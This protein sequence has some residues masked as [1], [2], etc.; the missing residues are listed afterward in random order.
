MRVLV[1]HQAA[2][3]DALAHEADVCVQRD[4][5][6]AALRALG[7]NV[8]HQP[9]T[10]NL[11]ALEQ[12]LTHL[13]PDVVFNL[14]E[15]LGDTDQL[16]SLVP[17]LLEARGIP[18]T[19]FGARAILAS[20]NK[21]AAKDT[22]RAA[23]V[24]TPDWWTRTHECTAKA[25]AKVIVKAVWEHASYGLDA[26]SVVPFTDTKHIRDRL[27]QA[28]QR[29][30]RAH[31]AEAYVAGREF[32]LSLLEM[33]SG[34]V[35]VLPPAEIDFSRFPADE[36]HV[37]GYAAKWEAFSPQSLGTPRTF[38]FGEQDSALL[39]R[40]SNVALQVWDVL[41]GRGYARVDI[42]VDAQG[43]PWVLELNANPC[44]SP[45]AGFAAALAH[46]GIAFTQAIAHVL[47]TAQACATVSR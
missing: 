23:Q 42:R 44:L 1:L 15:S 39:G 18:F 11:A 37:V 35:C 33:D 4:A 47:S 28:D 43:T 24:P 21:L 34:E 45:D 31:F 3:E 12:T 14:V 22:L 32:N 7:H 19:G 38:V 8:S 6:V 30:G 36:P 20:T 27:A 40:V 9:V 29:T 26:A 46:A 17:Q 25:C 13:N 16:M 2:G 10:L 41:G 5:V